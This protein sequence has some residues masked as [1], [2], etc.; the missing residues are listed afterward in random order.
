MRQR[1]EKGAPRGR[2]LA[3]PIEPAVDGLPV[4]G[5]R[6]E[7]RRQL[8]RRRHLQHP[9]LV[10]PRQRREAE[11]RRPT[12]DS[13][14]GSRGDARRDATPALGVDEGQPQPLLQLQLVGGADAREERARAPVAAHEQV[15]PVVDDVAGGLV[16][17]GVGASA[18][19]RPPLEQRHARARLD[20]RVAAP[21]PAKPPPMTTTCFRAPSLRRG[22]SAGA[23]A[24][25]REVAERDAHLVAAAHRRLL[26][27]D[28]ELRAPRS[29]RGARS[30]CRP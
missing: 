1:M 2:R 5:R 27:E 7:A 16:D 12:S 14:P 10:A 26:A 15:L 9:E 22:R 21:S 19:L 30:R 3:Q 18:E 29:P 25:L 8:D 24:R 13:A 28:V 4:V 6:Q 11:E 17:D 20:S 23:T